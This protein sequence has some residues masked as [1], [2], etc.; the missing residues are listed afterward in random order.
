MASDAT[1]AGSLYL[2]VRAQI[3][4]LSE[5]LAQ[6]HNVAKSGSTR[7]QSSLDK[8]NLNKAS[9]SI[10]RFQKLLAVGFISVGIK[11]LASSF[12]ETAASFETMQTKLE[13]LEGSR[14]T[15]LFEALNKMALEL[16]VSTQKVVQS[17]VTMQAMGLEPTRKQML[18]L[19][20]VAAVLGDDVFDRVVLQLGQMSAKGKI[21]AQDLNIMAEAGINVRKILY[22]AFGKSVE[23]L[24]ASGIE[25][26]KV[27]DAIFE[28]MNK[29]FSGSSEKIMNTWRGVT[30]LMKS[31]WIEIER[32]IA[33]AGV[34]QLLKD[35]IKAVSDG[36]R[37]WLEVNRET[38]KQ[39]LPGYVDKVRVA[40][41]AVK[42]QFDALWKIITYDPAIIEYGLIGLLI[43]GKKGA[44]IAGGL[45]HLIK[46]PEMLAEASVLASQGYVSISDV[47]MA[48]YKQLEKIIENGRKLQSGVQP[49]PLALLKSHGGNLQSAHSSV[50]TKLEDTEKYADGWRRRWDDE[51]NVWGYKTDRKFLPTPGLSAEELKKTETAMKKFQDDYEK[52][53]LSEPLYAL[54][55]IDKTRAEYEKAGHDKVKI[56]QWY[57][58][59]VL[60]IDNKVQDEYQKTIDETLKI[61]EKAAEEEAKAYEDSWV[62]QAESANRALAAQADE[63]EKANKKMVDLSEETARA[64]QSNF[65]DLFFDAMTGKLKTFEDYAKAVFDSITRMMADLAGQQLTRSLFGQDMKGGGWLSSLGSLVGIGSSMSVGQVGGTMTAS[66]SAAASLPINTMAGPFHSGGT[67]GVTGGAMRSIPASYFATAPRLHQG[68]AADEFPAVLQKGEQVI[69]KGGGK[70]QPIVHMHFYSQ[71]GKYDRESVSQAQSGLYASL[72]RANRRNS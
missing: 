29:K 5:D 70:S 22:E 54:A 47:A 26:S 61:R 31:N 30:E 11:N 65:S 43:G 27:T 58:A 69:P 59:E 3:K 37:N 20:D 2:E 39:D 35:E 40:V 24:Q 1:K 15:R 19:S 18:I 53:T 44:L 38:I 28:G 25:I 49:A 41:A 10:T 33:S 14:G 68:L 63:Y 36:L 66:Q 8:I 13:A 6:A 55:S 12:I 67:V 34:F 32:V 9:E 46:I 64:M 57:A 17:F 7:I 62:K 23:E 71:N 4:K 56:E 16:P 72:S 21:M 60:K 50:K 48:D 51:W 52:A 45:A 42:G